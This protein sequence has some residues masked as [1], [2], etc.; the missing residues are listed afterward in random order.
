MIKSLKNK[1]RGIV[2]SDFDPRFYSKIVYPKSI[3][4]LLNINCICTISCGRSGT[5]T[6]V[7]IAKKVTS[8][9]CIHAPK[10]TNQI[11]SNL[12]SKSEISADSAFWAY[13]SSRENY[14]LRAFS[15]N[16]AYID[17][18][19]KYLPLVNVIAKRMPNTKFIHFVRDPRKFIASGL[20][21]GYFDS[22]PAAFWGYIEP[23]YTNNYSQIE[24]IAYF[25]N[26]ANK[27]AE[28]MKSSY[29]SNRVVTIR[30][31][32]MFFDPYVAVRALSGFG[33][34][35]CH[36]EKLIAPHK[37]AQLKRRESEKYIKEIE[38]AVIE[39]CDTRYTYSYN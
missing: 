19:C 36:T 4:D 15:T 31:E 5:A 10:V 1:I 30:A 37:N 17:G 20:D 25:W 18:D 38:K 27:I 28:K 14:F 8:S 12:Y 11:V 23:R 21:R 3:E 26:E 9:Y 13:L 29:G 34:L 33:I 16:E 39:L 35:T 2:D 6:F 32:D 24:K 7:E 22:K